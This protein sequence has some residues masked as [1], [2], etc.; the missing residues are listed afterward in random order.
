[1]P[2]PLNQTL[3]TPPQ[4]RAPEGTFTPPQRSL[5]QIRATKAGLAKG[6]A[7]DTWGQF[8]APADVHPSAIPPLRV[9]SIVA[10]MLTGWQLCELSCAEMLLRPRGTPLKRSGA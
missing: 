3:V 9:F 4:S 8:N 6:T 5:L 7:S 10:Q 1:M 2:Q